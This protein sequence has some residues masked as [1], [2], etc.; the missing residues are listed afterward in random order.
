MIKLSF[1]LDVSSTKLLIGFNGVSATLGALYYLSNQ[2]K[3]AISLRN[4]DEISTGEKE[5]SGCKYRQ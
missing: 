4:D 5:N 2:N 1:K 3:T